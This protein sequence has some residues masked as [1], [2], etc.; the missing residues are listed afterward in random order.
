MPPIQPGVTYEPESSC[1]PYLPEFARL[2]CTGHRRAFGLPPPTARD[3]AGSRSR[4]SQDLPACPAARIWLAGRAGQARTANSNGGNRRLASAIDSSAGRSHISPRLGICHAWKADGRHAISVQLATV[5]RGQSRIL[6]V[7]EVGCS[8]AAI[9]PI[10]KVI[11]RGWRTC[12]PDV[13]QPSTHRAVL[14]GSEAVDQPPP[15]PCACSWLARSR[16]EGP[17]A[18]IT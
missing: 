9:C 1:N 2:A 4:P 10:P 15:D 5:K 7:S 13:G 11:V 3:V 17:P 8:S 12:G 18:R 16:P 6:R 14:A